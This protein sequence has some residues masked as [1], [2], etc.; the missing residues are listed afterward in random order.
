MLKRTKAITF[1]TTPSKLTTV[2]AASPTIHVMARA[3]PAETA[4]QDSLALAVN[5]VDQTIQIAQAVQRRPL[6]S[7]LLRPRAVTPPVPATKAVRTT[8][9]ATKALVV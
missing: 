2:S 9:A 5:V 8:F 4:K 3:Q 6:P 7:L 1:S